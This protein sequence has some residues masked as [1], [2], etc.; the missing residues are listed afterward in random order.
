M[1]TLSHQHP[2]KGKDTFTQSEINRLYQLIH[3]RSSCPRPDKNTQKKLRDQMRSIGFFGG[4]DWGINNCQE[5]HLTELINSGKIKVK[6][7]NR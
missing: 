4:D 5:H 2:L 3:Q 6:D 7:D 1:E